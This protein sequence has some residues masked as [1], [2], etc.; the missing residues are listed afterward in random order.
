[1]CPAFLGKDW[2][3]TGKNQAGG[4]GGPSP[5]LPCSGS[6][7]DRL[8]ADALGLGAFFAQTLLLVGFVF[9]IVVE[10]KPQHFAVKEG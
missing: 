3:R 9:L 5:P 6:A 4:Q 1:M 7:G 10:G 8:V 2:E